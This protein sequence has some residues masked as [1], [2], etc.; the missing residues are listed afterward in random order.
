MQLDHADALAAGERMRVGDD[1]HHLLVVERLEPE[2]GRA[3][4]PVG[5]ADVELAGV[6][7]GA[8]LVGGEL[9]DPDPHR[10]VARQEQGHA[11]RDEA[12]V[13]GVRGAD[14]HLAGQVAAARL[15]H[16]DALVDLLQRARREGE[17]QLAGL[18][19]HH[20]LADAVE[21]RLADLFLELAD[22]VRQRRL[23][24]VDPLGRAREAQAIGQ[25]HEVAKV[26]QLHTNPMVESMSSIISMRI[27]HFP[28]P[29]DA[30]KLCP[31]RRRKTP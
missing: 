24:D 19:R 2:V 29:C 12:D 8:D 14:A 1:E 3:A 16:R 25:R 9:L 5:D 21:E 15:E 27:H 7:P 17:E 31:P 18:G 22:L 13:E 30:P 28:S 4:R 20:L 10:R 11:F 26:P 23:G 6:Q